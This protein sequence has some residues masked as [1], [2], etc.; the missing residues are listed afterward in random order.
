MSKRLVVAAIALFAGCKDSSG[1][2]G[3]AGSMDF[4]FTGAVNGNFTAS[5]ALPSSAGSQTTSQW[6]AGE[7]V[8]VDATLYLAASSP[9]TSTSRDFVGVIIPRTT[10]GSVTID[11]PGCTT[12]CADVV[13]LLGENNSGAGSP[14]QTCYLSTGTI[15]I[16][17]ITASRVDGTFSGSGE[18]F[19]AGTGTSTA[20]TISNGTFDVPLVGSVP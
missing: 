1:P 19:A 6:A 11:F 20:F 10:A 5:G 12:D 17:E 7:V 9:R 18:C 15:T 16:A 3:S 8:Q 2:S 4:A 13:V 14:L